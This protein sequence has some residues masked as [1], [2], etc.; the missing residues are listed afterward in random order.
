MRLE[1]RVVKHNWISRGC[2]WQRSSAL[3]APAPKRSERRP[4]TFRPDGNN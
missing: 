2:A 3:D 4:S 1:K